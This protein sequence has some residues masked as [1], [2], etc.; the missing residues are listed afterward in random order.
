MFALCK[1]FIS[2]MAELV[3]ISSTN[4][5]IHHQSRLRNLFVMYVHKLVT[6]GVTIK[7]CPDFRSS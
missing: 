2:L 7:E 4:S 5:L 3:L 1:L 6:H